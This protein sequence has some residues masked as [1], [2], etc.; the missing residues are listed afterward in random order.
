M[1]SNLKGFKNFSFELNSRRITGSYWFQMDVVCG[2]ANVVVK[3][4][5]LR[6][7]VE[8]QVIRSWV[9]VES[10]VTKFANDSD[11][12]P[13]PG[14]ENS[15]SVTHKHTHRYREREIHYPFHSNGI[16][17]CKSHGFTSL[18]IQTDGQIRLKKLLQI[19][20]KMLVLS[21]LLEAPNLWSTWTKN[22]RHGLW[23]EK[24]VP[25]V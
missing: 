3:S 21:F 22:D 7:R 9:W 23:K 24:C 13:S 14:L 1:I 8:S 19:D 6:V 20:F 16:C 10:L 17:Q 11:S 5:N 18:Y 15:I 25:N 4:P 12:S 2:E